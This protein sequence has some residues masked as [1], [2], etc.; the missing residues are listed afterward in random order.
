ML[1]LNEA[2]YDES[3]DAFAAI[4][5]YKTYG[6]PTLLYGV[7]SLNLNTKQTDRLTTCE[8]SIVKRILKLAPFHHSDLLLA[9]LKLNK[10]SEKLD[11]IKS[12]FMIR[13]MRN[14]YT[15]SFTRELLKCYNGVPHRLSILH[16]IMEYTSSSPLTRHLT[17]K[18]ITE[19]AEFAHV[20]VTQKCNNRFKYGETALMVRGILWNLSDQKHY[21]VEMLE[22][23]SL[24]FSCDL[25]LTLPY[26]STLF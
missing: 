1:K 20:N 25:H 26:D 12:A 22:P 8:T 17:I 3:L 4:Q 2:G 21:L 10:M 11:S 9:A 6:R 18:Q 14:H 16:P 7:E 19:F 23:I 24:R 15:K 13:L 5:L